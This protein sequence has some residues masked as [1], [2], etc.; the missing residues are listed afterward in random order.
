MRRAAVAA[1]STV[2]GLVMLLSFKTH[3]LPTTLDSRPAAIADQPTTTPPTTT[4][5]AAATAPAASNPGAAAAT[6]PTPTPTPTPTTAAAPA[7]TVTVT[8]NSAS[9]RYGPVVVQITVTDGRI[10]A[11]DAVEYPTAKPRDVQINVRAVPQ[12]NAEA[13]AAQS[14]SIHTISG[15][16]YTSNG[17]ITSLQSALDKAGL[18]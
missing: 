15:A 8:G 16:T 2:L 18:R 13:L 14:A 17:Y 3:A 12:L 1:V 5:A 4:P 9:T 6:T 10:T 7:K 11:V